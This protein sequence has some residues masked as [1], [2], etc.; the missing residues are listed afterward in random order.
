MSSWKRPTRFQPR[1]AVPS[2]V[3][4]TPPLPPSPV[5]LKK[6]NVYYLTNV[7]TGGSYKY[8]KDLIAHFPQVTFVPILTYGDL[9]KHSRDFHSEHILLVQYFVETNIT[10]KMIIEIV[11]KTGI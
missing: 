2:A 3:V 7:T 10:C 4:V 6:R 5:P 1:S 8:I 9:H 11:S